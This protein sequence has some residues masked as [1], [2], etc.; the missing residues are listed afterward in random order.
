MEKTAPPSRLMHDALPVAI[1]ASLPLVQVFWDLVTGADPNL[2]L[3]WMP[4]PVIAAL[5]A[6][7]LLAG[8][9]GAFKTADYGN[10]LLEPQTPARKL[11]LTLITLFL[12]AI[13]LTALRASHADYG[14]I[15]IGELGLVALTSLALAAFLLGS[16]QSLSRL[17]LWGVTAGVATAATL[18]ILLDRFGLPMGYP[19][20]FLPGFIHIR[21]MGFSLAMALMAAS[22]LWLTGSDRRQRFSLALCMVLL[23]TA[24]F[25][26]GGRGALIAVLA[27]AL[28]LSIPIAAL[29]KFLAP[30][31]LT[32]IAGAACATAL[33]GPEAA[34]FGLTTRMTVSPMADG[35]NALTS[36]RLEMWQA[37]WDALADAPLT[38]YGYAQA[39]WLFLD[40]GFAIGHLHAHSIILDAA[41]ALGI[42]G[43][44]ALGVLIVVAWT[45]WVATTRKTPGP[46]QVAGISMVTVFLIH[47]LVDGVYFYAQALVPLAVAIALLIGRQSD[48]R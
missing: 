26:S 16:G 43:A 12:A 23:W 17:L 32:A 10:R 9:T 21:V 11:T 44:I 3:W 36:G 8:L 45:R 18:A 22:G 38:G 24:L 30:L 48:H 42:L 35:A 41:L 28:I 7:V 47:A 5:G 6:I 40:A 15:K 31:L 46:A 14:L 4:A 20:L 39:R 2:H 27:T 19:D 34:E 13:V 37:L 29:R 25:W 1:L 33:G